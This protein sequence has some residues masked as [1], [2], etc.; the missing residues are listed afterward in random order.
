MIQIFGTAA[1]G[2]ALEMNPDADR[3]GQSHDRRQMASRHEL[4]RRNRARQ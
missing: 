4:D 3:S 1:A 2:K